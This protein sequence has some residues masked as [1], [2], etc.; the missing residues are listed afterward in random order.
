MKIE[1]TAEGEEVLA[2]D[3]ITLSLCMIV[4]DEALEWMFINNCLNNAY[5]EVDEIVIL[6]DKKF[7]NTEKRK[8]LEEKFMI[9]FIFG[10]W[11]NDFSALRNE[12]IKHAKGKWVLVLDADEFIFKEDIR[13]MKQILSLNEN[14]NAYDA[15]ELQQVTYN[16]N[17]LDYKWVALTNPITEKSDFGGAVIVPIIRLFRNNIG[18]KFKHRVHELVDEKNL[19]KG[20]LEIQIHHFKYF[21]GPE[22]VKN[23]ELW[24]LELMKIE[25]EENPGYAKVFFDMG[26]LY[27]NFLNDSENALKY[28]NKAFVLEKSA[29]ILIVIAK[30]YSEKDY[31]EKAIETYKKAAGLDPKNPFIFANKGSVYAKTGKYKEA[32]ENY[33]KAIDLGIGNPELI[34][35]WILQIESI[36][37]KKI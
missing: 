6:T 19:R 23:K 24:T 10:E 13:K 27:L 35:K 32:I 17:K 2:I 30:I 33:K 22:N 16:N 7:E 14:L 29:E 5:K 3:K 20:D 36:I 26:L 8:E 31:T 28:L 4:K 11:D 12:S 25:A 37:N 1:Y 18:I 34:K 15:F 21:K 9:K